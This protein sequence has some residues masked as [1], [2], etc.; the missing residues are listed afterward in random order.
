MSWS[1]LNGMLAADVEKLLSNEALREDS[2]DLQRAISK[3]T[4]MAVIHAALWAY[5]SR[6]G[7]TASAYAMSHLYDALGL[8]TWTFK[9]A[10]VADTEV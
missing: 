6:A 3:D 7:S 4:A 1:L 9:P 5:S 2:P 8:E 10:T